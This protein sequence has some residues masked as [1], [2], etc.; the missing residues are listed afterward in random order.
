M[1][2][3]CAFLFWLM[4]LPVWAGDFV[5]EKSRNWHQWRGP[6]ATGV[7]PEATPPLQ[8]D[9]QKNV[10]W[11]F[12]VPGRGSSTPIV[13]NDRVWITTA[14]NTG[15]AAEAAPAASDQKPNPFGIKS[16]TTNFRFVLICLDR[17]SGRVLW[18]KTAT[19]GLPHEGHHNDNSFA[20]ASPTTDGRY[21]YVSFGSRGIYCYDVDGELVWKR[22]LEE[23]ETRLSFGE[24][25]SP[26]LH[27]NWLV[28]NRDNE[29]KSQILALDAGSGEIRWKKNREEVSAWA[30]PLVVEYGDQTQVITSASN[31]V[32]SYD[33]ET[34][35]VVWECGGQ[36]GNVIPSPVR[37]GDRVLCMSGYRGSA[38]FAIPL[39]SRGDV[40]GSDKISWQYPRDTPYVPSPL[41]YGDLLYFTK[42][43]SAILTRLD[44]ATGKPLGEPQRLQDLSNIYASPVG[45]ADRVYFVGRDGTT[46]VIQHGPALE[47]LATNKLA[48]PIDASP[49]LAG[50]DLFLRGRKY[51]YCISE[52]K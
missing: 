42:S 29:G 8:W 28:L 22:P 48:D 36:V 40:T 50:K 7:A 41:L 6:E 18:E 52:A 15:Q 21:V 2:T 14:I 4:A 19:E 27:E 39:D 23:V 46:M 13:W 16:P 38:S 35:Q 9:D 10:R 12:E 34:G 20:S 1:K 45:A 24:A 17:S 37:S 43:N 49:A 33:L 11:K 5:A 44:A 51:L 30:T 31:R 47:P 26:V 3:S 32:R 25:S